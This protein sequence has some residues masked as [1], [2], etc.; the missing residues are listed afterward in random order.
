MSGIVANPAQH[1]I[2]GDGLGDLCDPLRVNFAPAG[3][4]LAEGYLSDHGEPFDPSTGFGWDLDVVTNDRQTGIPIELDT[5]ATT[6][7]I[8]RWSAELP[9]G[10]YAVQ[11]I[12]G[13]AS[14]AQGPHQIEVEGTLAIDGLIT[15]PAAFVEA[16]V[17]VPVRDGHIDLAVG[18]GILP[19]SDPGSSGGGGGSGSVSF[20]SF[21]PAEPEL[22][23]GTSTTTINLVEAVLVD[24]GMGILASV[25]FQPTGSITP[26]GYAADT[27]EPF[28]A[29]RGY[30]WDQSV[31]TLDRFANVPQVDDTFAF[32]EVARVWEFGLSDGVYEIFLVVGDAVSA[33]GPHLVSIEG[34]PVVAGTLTNGGEFLRTGSPVH[35]TDGRLTVGIGGSEGSTN[36][37][38]VVVAM[39]A[40]DADGDGMANEIDNC[41]A[42][43]NADQTDGDG[44]GIGDACDACVGSSNADADGDGYCDEVDVCPDQPNADQA[45]T[46]TDGMGDVCDACPLDPYNDIDGDGV[47]GDADNCPETSNHA[48]NDS[49]GDGVGNR[50]DNCGSSF[51]P[52][53]TD[54]DGDGK[55]DAC[56]SN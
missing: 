27:G 37:C 16:T 13:D 50:C 19:P 12:S 15:E 32:S 5:F 39:A 38:Q 31:P 6:S 3:A 34:V 44:D 9:N 36:L 56:D 21:G 49:D 35:V 45:D 8:R 1:D 41:P 42:S 26:A 18:G 52:D 40:A 22:P 28:D 46:D 10:D 47:C 30:G 17:I 2:D 51:N 54:S 43:S 14:F 55:G 53:Q 33:S 23:F 29:L 25:N 4:L 7:E 24:G 20:G 11:V 48:Q